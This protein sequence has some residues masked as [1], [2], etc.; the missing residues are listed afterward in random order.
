MEARRGEAKGE[1]R[2]GDLAHAASGWSAA[3]PS[4]SGPGPVRL[5]GFA[6]CR[7]RLRPG[8]SLVTFDRPMVGMRDSVVRVRS[9]DRAEPE[10]TLTRRFEAVP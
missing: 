6:R 7:G 9:N 5:A 1:S 10:Q 4:T 8:H 2:D 3:S